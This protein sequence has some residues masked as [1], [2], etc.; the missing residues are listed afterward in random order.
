MM[1]VLLVGQL[2]PRYALRENVNNNKEEE[3]E[4][5]KVYSN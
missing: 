5:D 2:K 1:A 4:A 3:A